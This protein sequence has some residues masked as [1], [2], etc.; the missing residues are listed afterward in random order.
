[1]SLYYRL[2]TVDVLVL[3]L[4]LFSLFAGEKIK[5]KSNSS[6]QSLEER[7]IG[8]VNRNRE[9]IQNANDII[10]SLKNEVTE[11]NSQLVELLT[12]VKKL[13]TPPE[14][15]AKKAADRAVTELLDS[16]W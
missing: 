10:R 4:S 7:T 1:M 2:V 15:R 6:I 12:R 5:K 16:S 9:S 8:L 14:V 11:L 3:G 13:E